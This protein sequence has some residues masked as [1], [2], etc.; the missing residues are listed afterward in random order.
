MREKIIDLVTA[1][2]NFATAI[3][4]LYKATEQHSGGRK[5]PR[6]YPIQFYHIRKIMTS[7][8]NVIRALAFVISVAALIIAIMK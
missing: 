6:L 2:I 4:V 5:L 3:I 8:A 7:W 1:L